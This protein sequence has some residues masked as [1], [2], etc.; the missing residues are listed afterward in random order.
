MIFEAAVRGELLLAQIESVCPAA[1]SASLQTHMNSLQGWVKWG[2]IGLMIIAAII[3]LGAILA[4]RIF[5]HPHASRAGTMGL[6]VVLLVAVGFVTVI[7]IL[8]GIVGSGG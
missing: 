6:A 2:V 3:S 5:S 8:R 1:P 7:G 4:G